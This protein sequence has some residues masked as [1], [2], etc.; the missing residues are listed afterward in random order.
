MRLNYWRIVKNI[1]IDMIRNKDIFFML[2]YFKGYL[3]MRQQP[4]LLFPD[5]MRIE[6]KRRYARKS[7]KII[8]KKI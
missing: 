4:G 1:S 2:V 7:K 5:N 6:S 8:F 3:Y